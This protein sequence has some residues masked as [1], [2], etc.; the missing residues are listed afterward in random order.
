MCDL[1]MAILKMPLLIWVQ[2][3]LILK[4][5]AQ[6]KELAPLHWSKLLTV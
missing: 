1:D 3:D 4:R 6:D 2:G 5:G